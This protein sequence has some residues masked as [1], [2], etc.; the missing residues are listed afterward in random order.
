VTGQGAVLLQHQVQQGAHAL[1]VPGWQGLQHLAQLALLLRRKPAIYGLHDLAH[2]QGKLLQQFVQFCHGHQACA[3][4]ILMP[5]GIIVH[6]RRDCLRYLRKDRPHPELTG[7]L[8][9]RVC[10]RLFER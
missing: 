1:D 9:R 6:P 4:R 8:A 10:K 3:A 7:L 5:A 2:P